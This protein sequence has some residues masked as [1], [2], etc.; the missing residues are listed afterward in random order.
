VRKLTGV[1]DNDWA[2]GARNIG[3]STLLNAIARCSG[4]VGQL[5]L[6]EAPIQGTTLDVIK[7]DGSLGAQAKLFDMTGLLHGHQLTS[8]LTSE[9]IDEGRSSE[10]GDAAQDLQNKG[11]IY[12]LYLTKLCVSYVQWPDL[13]PISLSCAEVCYETKTFC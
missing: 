2:M 3:K 4:V 12:S 5:S 10:K 11:H 8:R 7:V 9:E 1:R 13:F 6:T